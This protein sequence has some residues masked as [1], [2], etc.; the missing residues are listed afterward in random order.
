MVNP[1]VFIYI[2]RFARWNVLVNSRE[3][4]IRP[5]SKRSVYVIFLKTQVPVDQTEW[6]FE[7]VPVSFLKII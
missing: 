4:R 1:W 7:A 6:V 5:I 3:E 2:S